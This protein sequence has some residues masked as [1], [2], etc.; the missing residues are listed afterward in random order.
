MV[1]RTDQNGLPGLIWMAQPGAYWRNHSGHGNLELVRKRKKR[2]EG[3]V[4][5]KQI[6]LQEK[7]GKSGADGRRHY[8]CPEDEICIL[9]GYES[10]MG[11]FVVFFFFFVVVV[12]QVIVVARDTLCGEEGVGTTSVTGIARHSM[13]YTRKRC[14]EREE[15]PKCFMLGA[16]CVGGCPRCE[17]SRTVVR[18]MGMQGY[19]AL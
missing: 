2:D 18:W 4:P 7:K 17:R 13:A 9:L 11:L 19:P 5:A 16:R 1:G 3:A 8:R 12:V 6:M 15:I 14:I 10:P